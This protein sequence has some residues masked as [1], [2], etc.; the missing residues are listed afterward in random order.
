MSI[1][2]IPG[3]DAPAYA[4]A[5]LRAR[6]MLQDAADWELDLLIEPA[7]GESAERHEDGSVSVTVPG[8]LTVT[9]GPFTPCEDRSWDQLITSI[10]YWCAPQKVGN[11]QFLRDLEEQGATLPAMMAGHKVCY[12]DIRLALRYCGWRWDKGSGS[13]EIWRRS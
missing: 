5:A 9:A 12:G 11:R 1:P 4:R 3:P 8:E 7:P 10:R 2:G 6:L 13:T